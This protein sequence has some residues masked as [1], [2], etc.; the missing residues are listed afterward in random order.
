MKKIHITTEQKILAGQRRKRLR[1]QMEYFHGEEFKSKD[2]NA[3]LPL[4]R[5]LFMK[6]IRCLLFQRKPD[7]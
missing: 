3:E 2:L 7:S 6:G 4:K 1:Y 5:I